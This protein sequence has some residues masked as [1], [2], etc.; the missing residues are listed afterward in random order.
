MST[1]DANVGTSVPHRSLAAR[2]SLIPLWLPADA[3]DRIAHDGSHLVGKP[4]AID[5]VVRYARQLRHWKLELA[6]YVAVESAQLATDRGAHDDHLVTSDVTVMRPIAAAHYHLGPWSGLVAASTLIYAREL[7]RGLVQHDN[8]GEITIDARAFARRKIGWV[9]GLRRFTVDFGG[10]LAIARHD[11]DLAMPA[12]ARENAPQVGEPDWLDTSHRFR[13]IVWTPDGGVWGRVQGG[14]SK[15]IVARVGLRGDAFGSDLTLQPRVELGWQG[16]DMLVAVRGGTYRRPAE[17][18][19]ELEHPELH[20]ERAT[21]LDAN[22]GIGRG[23][24]VLIATLY[25]ADRTHLI[26]R[27]GD[28]VLRNTGRGQSYGAEIRYRYGRAPWGARVGLGLGRATRQD[29]PASI[30]RPAEYDQPVHVDAALA[31]RHGGWTIGARFELRSGLP[32]TP[33]QASVYDSDRDAYTPILGR[34]YSERAPYHRQLD[35]RIDHVWTWS[36]L[37]LAAYL[38]VANVTDDRS[39]TDYAYSYDFT[40]RT[41]REAL[42]IVPT[43]G[44][45]GA[46]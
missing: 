32:Y 8:D 4:L 16:H 39:A 19:E 10:D 18:R 9:A 11:L 15:S 29:T 43:L 21:Q 25:A 24:H 26:E 1:L 20:P 35:L 46:L 17:D 5:E 30:D 6:A 2:M 34:L 45:R 44:V 28:G 41:T 14:L 36:R 7:T 12:Q 37:W 27:G 3:P 22:A 33:V 40:Q 42:P 13:G 38:D 23:A 31:W